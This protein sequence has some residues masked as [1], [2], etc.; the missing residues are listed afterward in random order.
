MSDD[1]IWWVWKM[2]LFQLWS[3]CDCIVYDM[4]I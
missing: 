3:V 2:Q 1:R 4:D